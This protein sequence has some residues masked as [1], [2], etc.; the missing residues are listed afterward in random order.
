MNVVVDNIQNK[1]LLYRI[2]YHPVLTSWVKF[3]NLTKIEWGSDDQFL[4]LFSGG[5]VSKATQTEAHT[6]LLVT[7]HKAL[8][9]DY[10]PQ[11][12]LMVLIW[13]FWVDSC[14][15]M[16][17]LMSLGFR[18][19]VY[20]LTP[21]Q[22]QCESER[23]PDASGS[24][25]GLSEDCQSSSIQRTLMWYSTLLSPEGCLSMLIYLYISTTHS[26]MHNKTGIQNRRWF[27]W[28]SSEETKFKA[29]N[30]SSPSGLTMS[31]PHVTFCWLVGLFLQNGAE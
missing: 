6:H 5:C 22:W 19:T 3:C 17:P 28:I 26:F 20:S 11:M 1:S 9:N 29:V 13:L 21:E 7:L 24:A 8:K 2:V 23:W 15:W 31:W 27:I 25:C 4:S 18:H 16:E 14:I 30:L 12:V 10:G